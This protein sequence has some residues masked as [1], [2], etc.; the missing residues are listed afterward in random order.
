MNEIKEQ[1]ISCPYC[2]KGISVLIDCSVEYQNY[3]EDCQVCC[4]PISLTVSCDTEGEP[5]V[6]AQHEN[7]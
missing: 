2:G 1:F 7:D 5:V 3:I 4:W 6:I